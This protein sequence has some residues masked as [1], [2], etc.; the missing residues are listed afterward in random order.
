MS[1]W[2]KQTIR[3]PLLHFL[4]IGGLLFALYYAVNPAPSNKEN[5]TI[6]DEQ[7]DRIEM[8]F[9]KEWNRPPTETEMKGLLDRYIQQE[10]YYRKALRMNLDQD[11]EMIR[12]RLEQKLRFVTND[13]ANLTVPKEEDLQAYYK[14]HK[15]NYLEQ[16]K[17]SFSHIYFSPDKRPHANE[18]AAGV[19][20]TLP[21]SDKNI[22]K[23][24]SRGDAFPFAYHI[25]NLTANEIDQQ[26]GDSFS[27]E[28]DKLPVGKW[29]GPILSGYGTHLIFIDEVKQP[30]EKDF[31]AIKEDVLRDYHYNLQNQYN[32]QLYAEFKKDYTIKL[33]IKDPKHNKQLLNKM[34]VSNVN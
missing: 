26:M 15:A 8:I 24:I 33:D 17:Y 10:V 11:D 28:L 16:K 20:P 5:I 21:Y 14:A 18:D 4:I 27:N 19:L 2:F 6:N 25:E 31:A 34:I 7:L 3:Q 9:Q 12:R 32:D 22:D 13:M 29:S 30:V 23:L 1:Q